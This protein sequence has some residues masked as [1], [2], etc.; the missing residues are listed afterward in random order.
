MRHVD[1]PTARLRRG[2]T[3]VEA[4]VVAII[5]GVLLCILLPAIEAAR[6]YRPPTI[7]EQEPSEG[8]RVYLPSGFSVVR[9]PYWEVISG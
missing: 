7:P 9:P 5:I 6:P 4:V 3:L 8:Y 1:R 2:F